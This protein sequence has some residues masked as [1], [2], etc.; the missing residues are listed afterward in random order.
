MLA[1]IFAVALTAGFMF[2]TDASLVAKIA[3]AALLLLSFFIGGQSM[4]W[5]LAGTLLQVALCIGVLVYF[6]VAR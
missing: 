3:V 4:M 2:I 5:A 6:K 1:P